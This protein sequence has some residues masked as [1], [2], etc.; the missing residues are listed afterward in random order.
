MVDEPAFI[1]RGARL[2][3][4]SCLR[5]RD[6]LRRETKDREGREKDREKSSYLKGMLVIHLHC[7]GATQPTRSLNKAITPTTASI[8]ETRAIVVNAL[9]DEMNA[10]SENKERE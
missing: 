10:H 6:C 7:P 3:F 4:I 1:R 5:R 2:R 9:L 8:S